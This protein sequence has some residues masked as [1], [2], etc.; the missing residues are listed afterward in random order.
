M[1][2]K[3]HGIKDILISK[4]RE[5]KRLHSLMRLRSFLSQSARERKSYQQRSWSKC[6]RGNQRLISHAKQRN[7]RK[8]VQMPR[9]SSNVSS[10]IFVTQKVQKLHEII[11]KTSQSVAKS[12]KRSSYKTN[13]LVKIAVRWSARTRKQCISTR[14]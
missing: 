14:E 9:M 1:I 4:R 10:A 5:S 3:F 11:T 8:I 2:I 12:T 13:N 7:M 6:A